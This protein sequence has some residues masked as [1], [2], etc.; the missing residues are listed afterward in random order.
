LVQLRRVRG[1]ATDGPAEPARA[2]ADDLERQGNFSQ[3][4]A[5]SGALRAIYDPWS[6]QTSADGSTITVWV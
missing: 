3:S 5:G 6:T 1:L 2:V 4:L